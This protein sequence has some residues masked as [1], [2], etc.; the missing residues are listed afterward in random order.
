MD[1]PKRKPPKL[2]INCGKPV[3]ER[4]NQ[5]CPDCIAKRVYNRQFCHF[6]LE[7]LKSDKSR[8]KWLIEARGYQCEECN[9]VEWR[10]KPL[11]LE[12]HHLDG[13]TDNNSADNLKLLCPNCHSQTE[14]FRQKNVLKDGK[15]QEVRRRRY[16]EGKTW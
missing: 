14:T 1:R 7:E 13:D 11:A 3:A 5:Y 8:R 10:G 2:C 6:A 15:R 12:L 9:L 16:A 4:H